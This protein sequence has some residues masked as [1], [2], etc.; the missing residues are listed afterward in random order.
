MA[1]GH[2]L[3]K[4]D[5][6]AGVLRLH[7]G[8]LGVV[9]VIAADHHWFSIAIQFSGVDHGHH[10]GLADDDAVLCSSGSPRFKFFSV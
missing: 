7:V 9:A 5:Q 2:V 1:E 10:I 8:F 4:V 3:V 6:G